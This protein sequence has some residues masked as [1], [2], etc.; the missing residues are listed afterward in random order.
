M[1][2]LLKKLIFLDDFDTKN[3]GKSSL[4]VLARHLNRLGVVELVGREPLIIARVENGVTKVSPQG[5]KTPKLK[6]KSG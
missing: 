3:P 5:Q 6:K 1:P 2:G 4:S